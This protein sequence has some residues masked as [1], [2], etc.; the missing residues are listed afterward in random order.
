M[1][2]K[3]SVSLPGF[4][5]A[6]PSTGLMVSLAF[7]PRSDFYRGTETIQQPGILCPKGFFDATSLPPPRLRGH[8]FHPHRFGRGPAL[9]VLPPEHEGR[10]GGVGLRGQ[11]P[12]D[13]RRLHRHRVSRPPA[14]R[15]HLHLPRLCRNQPLLGLPPGVRVRLR[16]GFRL[17][18]PARRPAS[19]VG[20][21]RRS[22]RRRPC[23]VLRRTASEGRRRWHPRWT[24]RGGHAGARGH[25][26]RA[27]PS[28]GEPVDGH[29][30]RQRRPG[31]EVRVSHR[32]SRAEAPGE[33]QG[34]GQG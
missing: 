10:H 2:V 22:P 26:G 29:Q 17:R 6:P 21:P 20:H 7:L 23:Y 1:K 27:R 16:R 34:S 14:V 5:R 25:Q 19:G 24:A 12:A 13:Q 11:R 18:P 8:P 32:E 4:S 31:A 3:A 30:D 9:P 28:A 15:L 33:G